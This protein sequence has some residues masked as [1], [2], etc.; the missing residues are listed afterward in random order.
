MNIRTVLSFRIDDPVM[1]AR[2]WHIYTEAFGKASTESVQDQMCYTQAT[3]AAALADE[4]YAK[5]V[6][7]RD[8]E[9]I[10]FGLVTDDMAKASVTY[11]NPGY[12]AAKFPDEYAAK[13][14]HYFTAIAVLPE[15]QGSGSFFM[16]MAAEM[17]AYIDTRGGVVLFDHSMET[18]PKLPAMLQRAI[19]AAQEL[20]DLG[21]RGTVYQEL[22]GQRYGIIRFTPKP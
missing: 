14:L 16:S 9:A 15:L 8:E 17:T 10:G 11:V 13:R 6:V 1:A 18:S 3:L 2:L 20:R 19:Q 4:G 7:Y 22:G 12:L 21:T 5:F